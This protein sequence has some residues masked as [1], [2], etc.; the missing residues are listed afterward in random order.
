MNVRQAR[1]IVFKF[2]ASKLNWKKETIEAAFNRRYKF[3]LIEKSKS[4]W[5]AP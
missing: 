1:K 5:I 3:K 4:A 2:I